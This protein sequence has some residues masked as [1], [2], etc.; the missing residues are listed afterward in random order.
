M[1]NAA[2]TA[3]SIILGML[4]KFLAWQTVIKVYGCDIFAFLTY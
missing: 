4:C 3:M 2:D 1:I